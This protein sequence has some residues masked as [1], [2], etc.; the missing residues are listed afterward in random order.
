MANSQHNCR[1]CANYKSSFGTPIEGGV[2]I[3]IDQSSLLGPYYA[4]CCAGHND[5]VQQ[6]WK[7]NGDKPVDE[8]AETSCYVGTTLNNALDDVISHLDKLLEVK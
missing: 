3:D 1:Y 2:L 6:W 7:D 5:V 4:K 8:A